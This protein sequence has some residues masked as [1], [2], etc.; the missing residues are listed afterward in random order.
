MK[1]PNDST[2]SRYSLE[3]AKDCIAYYKLRAAKK[4]IADTDLIKGYLLRTYDLFAA[5]GI[6]GADRIEHVHVRVY[7]GMEP[8]TDGRTDTDNVY[9]LFLVPVD[10]DGK[11]IIPVGPIVPGGDD[12]QFVYDFNT[13]CPNTCDKTS[14][15]FNA[16]SAAL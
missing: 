3:K 11:D 7:L 14:P 4:K 5:L 15:L 12:V 13:P 10:I 2:L 9:K 1:L 8:G 16:G 6:D